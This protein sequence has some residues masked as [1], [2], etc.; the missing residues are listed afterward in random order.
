MSC[1]ICEWKVY[2][3]VER[4]NTS[5]K[6]VVEHG[7]CSHGDGLERQMIGCRGEMYSGE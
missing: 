2:C 3:G 4:G 5:I 6:G 1:G 7:E